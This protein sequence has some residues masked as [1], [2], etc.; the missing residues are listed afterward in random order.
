MALSNVPVFVQT[1]NRGI[2]Q[3][4]NG[5]GT[6]AE[7]LYTAATN[8]SKVTAI[9]ATSTDTSNR[10]FNIFLHNGSTSYLLATAI[11]PAS[12][13]LDGSTPSVNCL[14][15]GLIP[16]LPVDNDGQQYLFLVSGDTIQVQLTTSS[17]TSGKFVNFYAVAGD[18]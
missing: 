17:V 13:G 4:T 9:I 10:T 5:N 11:V 15:S 3:Y 8:G 6:T 1:P 2:Y 12:S 18:F 16:G 7:T 14:N